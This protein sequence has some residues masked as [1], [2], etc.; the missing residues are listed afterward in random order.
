MQNKF[1]NS[2]LNT[3]LLFIL[4]ILMVI[5]IKIM[6]KDKNTYF[7]EFQSK[8]AELPVIDNSMPPVANSNQILGNKEDLI[9]F[10][11]WPGSKV[12]GVVSYRGK[13]SGGY[14]F[15]ANIL[16]NVL[17]AKKKL[18]RAGHGMATSDWMTS[19]P[20]DFEGNID[21]SGLP[22]GPAYIEIHNDNASGL[23]EHDKS[24]LIPVVI[25]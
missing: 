1:F 4:I 19:G 16:V 5:A 7:P 9:S 24:I 18:L 25:E 15:E 14:F 6:L 21:F 10:S 17:D 12:H 13:I 11:I 3:V 2:K 20:V 22:K 8:K 23:P